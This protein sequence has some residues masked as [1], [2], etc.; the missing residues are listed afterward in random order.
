MASLVTPPFV[1]AIAW[2]MLAAPNSGLL[3]Q[4]WRA[5]T[6]M[7]SDEALFDIYTLD[8]PDLRHRLLHLSLCLHPGGQRARP[9]AGRARGCLVDAGRRDL[10]DGAAHH[11]AAGAADLAGRRAGRLPAGAEPVRLARHPGH[12]GGLPH[13]HHPDLEPVPV[14]AQARARRGRL[15]AAAAADRRA[16]ARPGA[17]ARPARLC[18]AGRQVRRSRVWSGWA[19]LRWPAAAL[20]L[21]VLAM[22]L[23]LPYAALFNSAF[24]RVASQLRHAST[25][26]PCTTCASPSSSSAR[27]CRRSRTP[28]CWRRC[29]RR[30]AR[31]WR[32]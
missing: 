22:P 2:E 29:R 8:G 9:H 10:A 18:R 20:A 17:G 26:S 21:L 5:L 3:N 13:A 11:R 6:G 16:A 12:P 32:C 15:A 19:W 7:P 23:F 24:S 28:S 1:G 4:L 30:W 14:P 31:C 25:P 27:P